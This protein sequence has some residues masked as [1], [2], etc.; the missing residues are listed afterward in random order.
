MIVL[1]AIDL[2]N[3]QCV[4]LTQGRFEEIKIYSSE[5]E[6]LAKQF[7][8]M[9]AKMI[10][11]VDLNGAKTGTAVNLPTIVKILQNVSIPIQVGGGIRSFEQAKQLLELGV[12][13]IILGTSAIENWRLLEELVL[14]YGERIVVSIDAENGIVKT[15]GWQTN[16]GIR[17]LDVVQTLERL[18][19]QTIVYTDIAKDGMLEGPN[20]DMYRQLQ[21]KSKLRIIASGGLFS[22]DDL[23]HLQFL[24]LEGAI[25]GKAYYEGKLDFKEA[26]L[27]LQNESSPA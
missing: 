21:K 10:H 1:P 16:S 13:R 25:I 14:H 20:F 11:I 26:I 9:G 22:I 3:N 27:C 4:R 17:V 12:A 18:H 24:A 8:L 23:K 2:Y 7:E 15:R 6:L 5:P 19:V